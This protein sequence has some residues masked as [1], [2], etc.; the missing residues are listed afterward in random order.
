MHGVT[1]ALTSENFYRSLL[2]DE[3]PLCL[4]SSLYLRLCTHV[5]TRNIAHTQ[6]TH[7][8]I[9]NIHI[10]CSCRP[11]MYTSCV[12]VAHQSKPRTRAPFF[13]ELLWA[14]VSGT[15]ELYELPPCPACFLCLFVFVNVS[16]KRHDKLMAVPIHNLTCVG[17]N[18]CVWKNVS[19][20][21]GD[22]G[23]IQESSYYNKDIIIKS[24]FTITT[25]YCVVL[26]NV[27]HIQDDFEVNSREFIW[28]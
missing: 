13:F 2:D 28:W 18:N 20:V 8:C 10:M 27:S 12:R 21:Q 7:V 9:H 4:T 23:V 15:K 26:K 6:Y 17:K 5:N 16:C 11:P 3:L 25:E 22:F 14:N 1:I 24:V 19:H